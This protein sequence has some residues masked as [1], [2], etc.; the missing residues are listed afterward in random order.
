M[1]FIRDPSLPNGGVLIATQKAAREV[2]DL[3]P[4]TLII[5]GPPPTGPGDLE[6]RTGSNVLSGDIFGAE[7]GVTPDWQAVSDPRWFPML[8]IDPGGFRHEQLQSSCLAVV[9]KCIIT[10]G[11]RC[12][13][14]PRASHLRCWTRIVDARCGGWRVSR[15]VRKQL[16]SV[17]CVALRGCAQGHLPSLRPRTVPGSSST[18]RLAQRGCTAVSTSLLRTRCPTTRCGQLGV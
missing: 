1:T 5:G 18:R 10:H 8:I 12:P 11:G 2:K 14:S 15:I 4:G 7:T 3:P 9:C 16:T 17:G 6:A 13:I